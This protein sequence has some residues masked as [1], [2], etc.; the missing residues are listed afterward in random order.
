MINFTHLLTG[1]VYT[2]VSV[3]I[4]LLSKSHGIMKSQNKKEREQRVF[5]ERIQTSRITQNWTFSNYESRYKQHSEGYT[6]QQ[7]WLPCLFLSS[8]FSWINLLFIQRL[9]PLFPW[10]DSNRPKSVFFGPV[11]HPCSHTRVVQITLPPLF[12]KEMP[13]SRRGWGRQFPQ[14][15]YLKICLD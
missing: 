12:W 3:P 2:G 10:C 9:L 15:P 7:Q 14:F 8:D 13:L 11:P 1:V 6:G 4:W 5:R